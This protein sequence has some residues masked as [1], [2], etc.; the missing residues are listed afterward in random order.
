[1][2][3]LWTSLECTSSLD[4]LYVISMEEMNTEVRTCHIRKAYFIFPGEENALN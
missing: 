4:V 1:M 2:Y 3:Y